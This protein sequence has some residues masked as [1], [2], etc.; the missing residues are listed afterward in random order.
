MPTSEE[1]LKV[2][3]MIQ[4]GKITAEETYAGLRGI[5]I[6]VGW[7]KLEPEDGVYNWD[8]FDDIIKKAAANNKYVFTL[9]WINPTE[10]QWL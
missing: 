8:L 3:K 5:P 1:R 7:D 2:L 9:L 6:V 4:E 10:P